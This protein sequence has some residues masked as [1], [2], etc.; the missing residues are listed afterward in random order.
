MDNL[1]SFPVEVRSKRL[2][3]EEMLGKTTSEKPVITSTPGKRLIDELTFTQ[4]NRLAADQSHGTQLHV[5][6]GTVQAAGTRRPLFRPQSMAGNEPT[7]CIQK[8]WK[9]FVNT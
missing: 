4:F 9:A 8:S 6:A 2:G 1:K 5:P 7:Q 3:F